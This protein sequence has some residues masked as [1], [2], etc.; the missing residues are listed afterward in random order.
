MRFAKISFFDTANG[1]GIRTVLWVQGCTHRCMGCQNPTTW[2]I[3]GGR[4]FTTKELNKILKSLEP[5]YIK[6]I[7]Y[8]GGDPL[9]LENREEITKISKLIREKYPNKSQWLYT[10]YNWKEIKSLEVMKYIDVVVD[11]EFQIGERDITLKFRG[12]R[13]QRLIDVKKTLKKKRKIIL[14][15]NN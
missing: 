14:W 5:D 15:R 2:D 11:G 10:G 13:N 4:E 6:G 8:S 1:E 12:S 7:T 9:M 3:N